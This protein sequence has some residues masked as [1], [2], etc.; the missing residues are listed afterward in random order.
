M[1]LFSIFKPK[2]QDN[3]LPKEWLLQSVIYFRELGFFRK[4]QSMSDEELATMI[5]GLHK[6]EW[7]EDINPENEFSDLLLVKWDKDRIWWDDTEADVCSG[8]S[9]Y[10]QVL[11]EWSE[12]SRGTFFPENV[13]EHWESEE[14][15][16]TIT[17]THN[18]QNIQIH[19]QYLD[20]YIDISILSQVN[21]LIGKSGKEYAVYLPFD[22]TAFIIVVTKSEKRK[23]QKERNWR[24]ARG[25]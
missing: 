6:E 1:R 11:I 22:Q 20:D 16:I 24:F 7:D 17:F 14:G 18:Q 19:P 25:Y 13:Q 3:F 8:N 9:V 10:K 23:L 2:K 15:P 12:I 4:Y 5:G 21:Y